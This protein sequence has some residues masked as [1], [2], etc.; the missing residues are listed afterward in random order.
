MFEM[1]PLRAILGS[2]NSSEQHVIDQLRDRIVEMEAEISN[3]RG[4][5]ETIRRNA[6]L[7][8]IFLEKSHEGIGLLT[9]DLIVLRLIHS[10]VGYQE[11]EV[12][13]QSVLSLMH[14]D[15]VESFRNSFARLLASLGKT[16]PCEFRIRRRDGS[17]AWLS[18]QMT[19]MLDDPDVQAILLNVQNVTGQREQRAAAEKLESYRVCPDYAMFSKSLSG[20]ILDWNPG[21]RK[22]FGYAVEEIVGQRIETL[23]PAGLIDEEKSM[24]ERIA[25]GEEVPAFHTTRIH[26]DGS[27]VR[28]NLNVTPVWDGHGKVKA[29]A[30]LSRVID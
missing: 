10:S 6:R 3:L 27:S 1:H 21:A 9:P 18:G 4:L 13:G 17:W 5:D 24:R 30:H 29:I 19:D 28:I 25:R 26:K 20:V 8:S 23:V 22:A 15:D 16:A 11:Q 14:P 7:F 2:S 12:S